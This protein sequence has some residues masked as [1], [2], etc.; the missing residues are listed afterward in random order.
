VLLKYMASNMRPPLTDIMADAEGLIEIGTQLKLNPM[1][2]LG[3][4]I[5]NNTEELNHL[6]DNM[7]QI[8]RLEQPGVVPIKKPHT[9]HKIVLAAIKRLSRRLE[10]RQV[11]LTAIDTLPKVVCSKV[12]L[13]QV[14]F[15]IIENAIKYTPAKSPI[16]ITGTVAAEHVTISIEDKGPGV[17]LNEINKIF[18]KFY[19]GQTITDIQGMGLGLAICQKVITL[20]GGKIWAEN[21]PMGGAIFRFTLPYR[22]TAP[23]IL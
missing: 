22:A 16:S 18:E 14:F 15:N 2:A 21:S 10:N 17:P 4:R 7:K 13:E 20:H 1:L 19:R 8:T 11:T 5:Y 12:F 23:G 6:V 3:N 9:L